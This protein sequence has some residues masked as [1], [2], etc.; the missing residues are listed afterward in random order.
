MEVGEEVAEVLVALAVLDEDWNLE[1]IPHSAFRTPHFQGGADEG[2]D[3]VLFGG[4]VSPGGSVNAHVIGK[5]DGIV[6]EFG[7]TADEVLR[8]A[9]ATE[10]GE[11][12][13]GVEFGEHFK[14]FRN[15]NSDSLEV[16]ERDQLS[17]FCA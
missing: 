2:A 12:G 10:E 4:L 5:G 8:V 6:T 16:I 9:G 3:V 7:G 11:A 13:P 17:G 15:Q 1:I 14:E